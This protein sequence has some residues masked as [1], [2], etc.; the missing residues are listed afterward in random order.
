MQLTDM[1]IKNLTAK[2][3]DYTVSDTN[4]LALYI[5][6]AGSKQWHFRFSF[7]GKRCRISLGSYPDLS[8]KEARNKRDDARQLMAS[9]TDPRLAR[10]QERE[11]AQRTFLVVWERWANFRGQR[12]REGRQTSQTQMK[13]IFAKDVLPYIGHMPIDTIT[14]ADILKILRRIENRKAWA[15][16]TKC[17]SW[18]NQFFRYAIIEC[19]L[20]ANPAA[21]LAVVAAPV[22]PARHHPYLLMTEI[23]AFLRNLNRN[24][25]RLQT[26]LAIKLLLMT[27]VRTGELRLATQSQFDLE[28]ALWTIPAENVKQLQRNLRQ[29][30]IPPYVV[31]LSW[32]AVEIIKTLVGMSAASQCYLLAHNSNALKQISE[33]TINKAVQR[34]GYEGMLTGHGIRG[35]LST[36]LN[37]LGY[38]TEWIEAQLS[39]T[40]PNAVRSAYNHARYIEQRRK[41]MQEWSDLLQ[42]FANEAGTFLI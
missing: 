39:H 42:K 2:N 15:V 20:P 12:L 25:A 17:R 27:G 6:T 28:K 14:R 31:P 1:T 5:S 35:T 34:A 24:R 4:G 40:D 11:R 10:K 41:M 36:A 22:P 3:R 16:V 21:D 30:T 18:L 9:G 19:D 13:R 7:N 37:E 23:P 32:Q 26:I 8:L 33:N 29:R 38:P